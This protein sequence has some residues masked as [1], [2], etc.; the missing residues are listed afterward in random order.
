MGEDELFCFDLVFTLFLLFRQ[1][2]LQSPITLVFLPSVWSRKCPSLMKS[3]ELRHW[4][5][6]V[7]RRAMGNATGKLGP[8]PNCASLVVRWPRR[9]C[10]V[11]SPTFPVLLTAQGLVKQLPNHSLQP[12]TTKWA[13][14]DFPFV[15][16]Q[17]CE[18]HFHN[19]SLGWPV[20]QWN[21]WKHPSSL[22]G[23]LDGKGW[24]NFGQICLLLGPSQL[25]LTGASSWTNLLE[26][27]IPLRGHWATFSWLMVRRSAP[28][29]INHSCPRETPMTHLENSP[30]T[31][32]LPSPFLSWKD[33]N[34]FSQP[35]TTSWR[36]H[37]GRSSRARYFNPACSHC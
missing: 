24:E 9:S 31:K 4:T 36:M 26:Q 28:S 3:G 7:V 13:S 14:S 18:P 1:S 32:K 11:A 30:T 12:N 19:T 6:S 37:S 20:S 5:N 22:L 2:T 33:Q 8:E 17:G 21:E 15:Y 29:S 16:P 23:A 35:Q 27:H 34:R 25:E 10:L